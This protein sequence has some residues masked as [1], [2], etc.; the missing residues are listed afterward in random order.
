MSHNTQELRKT[1]KEAVDALEYAQS[2]ARSLA[3]T[4]EL[5]EEKLYVIHNIESTVVNCSNLI[6]KLKLP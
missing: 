2:L 5:D 6:Y 4:E 1:I 3:I